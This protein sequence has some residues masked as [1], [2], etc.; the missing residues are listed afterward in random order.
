M[1]RNRDQH[2]PEKLS[3]ISIWSKFKALRLG[4]RRR[5]IDHIICSLSELPTTTKQL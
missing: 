5:G 2:Q 3:S 1:A 4:A